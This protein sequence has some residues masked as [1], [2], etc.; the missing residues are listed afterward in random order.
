MNTTYLL[1]VANHTGVVTRISLIF[2]RHGANLHSLS[3][4]KTEHPGIVRIVI[5]SDIERRPA[6]RIKGQ[7]AKLVDIFK[8]DMIS[9][10]EGTFRAFGMMKIAC[11]MQTR[12]Q[13]LQLLEIFNGRV[14][15]LTTEWVLVEMTGTPEQLE[16]LLQVLQPYGILEAVETG[17]VVIRHKSPSIAPRPQPTWE[18]V[19]GALSSG[20]TSN[21]SQEEKRNGTNLL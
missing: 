5:T 8:V 4:A 15:E 2:R 1:D 20:S 18:V 17:P 16:G 14:L 11:T 3:T 13:I 21:S 10:E 9:H 19:P 12:P 7:L 6:E